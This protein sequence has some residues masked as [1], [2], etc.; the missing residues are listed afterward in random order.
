MNVK[1]SGTK[2][3]YQG[4]KLALIYFL[5]GLDFKLPVVPNLPNQPE[6][7]QIPRRHH[8]IWRQRWERKIIRGSEQR[9]GSKDDDKP[10]GSLDQL[11]MRLNPLCVINPMSTCRS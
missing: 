3:V 9:H 5:R 1:L 4:N 7:A 6:Q 11:A 2:V 10:R 8:A